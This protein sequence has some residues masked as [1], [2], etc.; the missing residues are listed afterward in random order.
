MK[1][2]ACV[3]WPISEIALAG[4][5]FLLFV[6]CGSKS[7]SSRLKDDLSR[8]SKILPLHTPFLTLIAASSG[9]IG[10]LPQSVVALTDLD[11]RPRAQSR[12]SKRKRFILKVL[13]IF[14][15]LLLLR[16]SIKARVLSAIAC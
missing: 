13:F 4:L 9:R 5:V 12:T 3:A 8:Q 16:M 7:T 10:G 15:Y 14:F 11:H 2:N 1:L 6:S